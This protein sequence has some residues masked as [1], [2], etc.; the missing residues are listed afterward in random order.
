MMKIRIGSGLVCTFVM[1]AGCSNEGAMSGASTELAPLDTDNQKASYG[2]GIQMGSQL[3]S[4]A[5]LLDRAALLRGIEDAL[6]ENDPVISTEEMQPILQA[7]GEEIE[8]VAAAERARQGEEN[9]MAGEAYLTENGARDGVTTTDSGLQYEVLQAGDGD[10]P[11]AQSQVRVHYRGTLLDGT[12]F[13]SSYERG[14]PAVFGAGQLIPGFTEALLLMQEGSHFRVTI[15]SDIAYGP[16][17]AGQDIV[18]DAT[19][20]FEIELLEILDG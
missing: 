15:P 8:A 5:E 10:N 1:L 17:G 2:I 6:Q 20:S 19:L 7:F 16:N 14:E 12:E 3:V 18:P 9:S 11:T 4:A 13:D